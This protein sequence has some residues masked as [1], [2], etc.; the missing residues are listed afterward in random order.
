M[1]LV[2]ALISA[3]KRT[4][5]S[6]CLIIILVRSLPI[7]ILKEMLTFKTE[8]SAIY[9]DVVIVVAELAITFFIQWEILSLWY[10]T[11]VIILASITHFTRPPLN[12]Y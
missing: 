2:D 8:H 1:N 10:S 6:D 9:R 7:F 4:M 11:S 12:I 3:L 5:S